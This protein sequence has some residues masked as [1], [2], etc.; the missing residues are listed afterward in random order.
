MIGFGEVEN[1]VTVCRHATPDGST[2]DIRLQRG[3]AWELR[4]YS[5]AQR[6][7]RTVRG[8]PDAKDNAGFPER[9]ELIACGGQN[10]KLVMTLVE[11]V[12]MGP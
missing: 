3:G 12:Q 6:L 10:Y 2:V 7:D 5:P 8:L 11:A 1:G 9:L 4:R